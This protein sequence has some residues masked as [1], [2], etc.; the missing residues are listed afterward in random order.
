MPDKPCCAKCGKEYKTLKTGIGVLEYKG[1]GSPY[2]ISAADLLGCP[3]C[4]HQ[5]TWGY[6]QA[7]HYSAE[8]RK[9]EGDIAYYQRHTTLI[10]VY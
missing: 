8:P 9:V 7:I 10:R 4:G 6:G 3:E 5:I 1:D 2:R